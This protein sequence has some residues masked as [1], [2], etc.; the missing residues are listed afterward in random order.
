MI[1]LV[2]LLCRRCCR[3]GVEKK[4]DCYLEV[5]A[6]PA[7]EDLEQGEHILLAA[8]GL[9]LVNRLSHLVKNSR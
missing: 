1:R 8:Q 5:D 3:I 4:R 2:E 6:R 7:A 9:G